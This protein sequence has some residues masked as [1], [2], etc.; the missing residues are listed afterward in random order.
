MTKRSS[1]AKIILHNLYWILSFLSP[2][3]SHWKFAS[4]CVCNNEQNV[5]QAWRVVFASLN[6]FT[7]L[8]TL[9]PPSKSTQLQI[10][11][12]PYIKKPSKKGLKKERKIHKIKKNFYGSSNK[13]GKKFLERK[14][15]DYITSVHIFSSLNEK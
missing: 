1:R 7:A 4:P 3:F 2:E 11:L 5:A 12:L 6:S 10:T 8:R 13:T 9:F 14:S 15:T